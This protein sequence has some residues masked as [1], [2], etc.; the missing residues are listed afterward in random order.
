MD[1]LEELVAQPEVSL[2]LG[3]LWTR[4]QRQAVEEDK[5]PVDI[6]AEEMVRSS[7]HAQIYH[8]LRIWLQQQD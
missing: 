7:K 6:A 8:L 2:A 3:Q 1:S 4:L 5:D